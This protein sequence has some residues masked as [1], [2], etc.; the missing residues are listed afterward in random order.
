MRGGK[1]KKGESDG[2]MSG[3]KEKIIEKL[4]EVRGNEGKVRGKSGKVK[5]SKGESEGKMR[6]REI[7]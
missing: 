6:G 5:G 1:D 3:N 7:S 4:V 2:K